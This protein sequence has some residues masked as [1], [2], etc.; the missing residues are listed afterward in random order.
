MTRPKSLPVHRRDFYERMDA[1]IQ[2]IRQLDAVCVEPT[3]TIIARAVG[4]KPSSHIRKDL[5]MMVKLGY[6]E[7]YRTAWR[8]GYD[9][10]V[11]ALTELGKKWKHLSNTSY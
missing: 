4:R 2:A 8:N 9:R 10:H 5:R 1:Y 11:Y 7:E 6:I 3:L